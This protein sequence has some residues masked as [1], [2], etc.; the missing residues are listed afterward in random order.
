MSR[1]K[2]SSTPFTVLQ[3]HVARN[4]TVLASDRSERENVESSENNQS[5]M[6]ADPI[7][8]S[9]ASLEAARE[10]HLLFLVPIISVIPFS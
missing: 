7:I 4:L 10:E 9:I 3:Y 1:K 2:A 5:E 6:D 8:E